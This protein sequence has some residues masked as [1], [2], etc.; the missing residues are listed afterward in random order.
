M[1]DIPT[2]IA[3]SESNIAQAEGAGNIGFREGDIGCI[4]W[5]AV[6]IIIIIY[7]PPE[8]DVKFNKNHLSSHSVN[9]YALILKTQVRLTLSLWRH[10]CIRA[11]RVAYHYIRACK[12][13]VPSQTGSNWISWILPAV[14]F[15]HKVNGKTR[16]RENMVWYWPLPNQRKQN[17]ESNCHGK[18]SRIDNNNLY[19]PIWIQYCPSRRRGQYW[20]QRGRYRLYL[21]KCSQ[22]YYYYLYPTGKWCKI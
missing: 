5:N 19:R 13:C 3:R 21:M 8:S 2:Y 14:Q 10:L 20:I 12:S 11:L 22:Y 4:S 15:T 1:N 9:M 6:N 7:T 16:K 17:M 18:S